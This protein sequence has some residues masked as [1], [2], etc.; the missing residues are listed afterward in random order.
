MTLL[1]YS[2]VLAAIT[3]KRKTIA[4]S[5]TFH[6]KDVKQISVLLWPLAYRL[7]GLGIDKHTSVHFSH[8][9]PFPDLP[10]LIFVGFN[11]LLCIITP[12]SWLLNSKRS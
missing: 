1:F 2:L 6:R 5:A 4:V 11:F 3:Y 7:S 12:S 9:F 8:T 10:H